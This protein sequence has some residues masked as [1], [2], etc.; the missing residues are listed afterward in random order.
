[1]GTITITTAL[2]NLIFQPLKPLKMSKFKWELQKG[3]KHTQCPACGKKTFK[4]YV[5]AADLKTPADVEKYGRCERINSCGYLA[6]PD[7]GGYDTDFTPPPP[8]PPAPPSFIPAEVVESTFFEFQ[9]NPFF[10]Y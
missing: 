2:L 3:S 1:M 6:Y 4:P 5:S 8:A 7:A 9:R 10:M